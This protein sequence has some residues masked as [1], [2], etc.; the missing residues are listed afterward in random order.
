EYCS[1]NPQV[2]GTLD[3]TIQFLKKG[4]TVPSYG[5]IYEG[6]KS[7]GK[8]LYDQGRAI[9]KNAPSAG[10]TLED[11]LKD[12]NT[13]FIIPK[14]NEDIDLLTF[15]TQQK[16]DELKLKLLG[17]D[18]RIVAMEVGQLD[19]KQDNKGQ[20]LDPN[21]GF[22]L[23]DNIFIV[24]SDIFRKKFDASGQEIQSQ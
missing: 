21:P 14:T 22:D 11:F 8:F 3:P 5:G 4:S 24:T 6:Q 15:L 20:P 9:P 12:S 19:P 10:T 17:D 13:E 2:K 18:Q 23:Q 1:D 16:K 7:L